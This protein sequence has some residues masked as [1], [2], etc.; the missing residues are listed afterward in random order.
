MVEGLTN[1]LECEER[2]AIRIALYEAS[3]SASN[4]SEILIRRAKS[5]SKEQGHTARSKKQR[6]NLARDEK[7]SLLSASKQLKITDKEFVRFAIIRLSRGIHDGSITHLT[8][9]KMRSQMELFRDWSKTHDGAPSK[10]TRLKKAAQSSWDDIE[11]MYEAEG[12]WM[13]QVK[14]LRR[15]YR[16]DSPAATNE[17]IDIWI[18]ESLSPTPFV[19]EDMFPEAVLSDSEWMIIEKQLSDMWDALEHYRVE[20]R[21]L[22]KFNND[23]TN[24]TGELLGIEYDKAKQ[25]M[26]EERRKRTRQMNEEIMPL[27]KIRKLECHKV[28]SEFVN[29]ERISDYIVNALI[30]DFFTPFAV[31]HFCH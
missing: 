10:L 12:E 30:N 29:R 26:E 27:W 28:N 9:S 14:E 11:D 17:E 19:F 1:Y 6:W 13:E 8:D 25:E 18:E 3:R 15:L 2:E 20:E 23:L 21:L 31:K 7:D 4:A 22:L 5:G 16:S 24:L